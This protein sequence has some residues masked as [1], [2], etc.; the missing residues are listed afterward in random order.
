[1]EQKGYRLI[2]D[3]IEYLGSMGNYLLYYSLRDT[4]KGIDRYQ[5]HVHWSFDRF[6]SYNS[7]F[8]Y[9]H[10]SYSLFKKSAESGISELK[11]RLPAE[12]PLYKADGSYHTQD[13]A[14]YH[15]QIAPEMAMQLDRRN[16]NSGYMDE[17][18]TAY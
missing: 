14:D 4:G 11:M 8:C 6:T 1:M 15:Y 3:N 2:H 16:G 9:A 10:G 5:R 12:H 17:L 13:L 18:N 7:R